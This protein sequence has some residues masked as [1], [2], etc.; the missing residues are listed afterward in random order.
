MSL[1]GSKKEKGRRNGRTTPRGSLLQDGSVGG[2]TEAV[3]NPLFSTAVLYD[4]KAKSRFENAWGVSP[5]YAPTRVRGQS[6]SR[7]DSLLQSQVPGY[8]GTQG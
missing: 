2:G 7:G 8:P 6:G 4:T 1:R 3:Y 5:D